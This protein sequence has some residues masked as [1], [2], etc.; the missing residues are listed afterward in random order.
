MITEVQATS[1]QGTLL[2][3]PLGEVSS[4]IFIKEIEGLDPV[5]AII[6]STGFPSQTGEQYQASKRGARDII[7]HLG[8]E[9]DY[10]LEEIADVRNRIYQFFMPRTTVDL[11]FVDHNGVVFGISGMIESC[12]APLFVQ[13]PAVD[14]VVRCFYSDFVNPEVVF[15]SDLTVSN[16][17]M[18]TIE[19]VGTVET[20]FKFQLFPDRDVDEFTLYNEM[21]NGRLRQF[22]FAFP[23]HVGDS[24]TIDTVPGERGVTLSRSSAQSSIL[25]AKTPQSVWLDFW[26]GT[27]KFRA[28][29]EGAGIPFIL[30]YYNRYG[31]L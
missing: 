10:F 18:T 14:V 9:A 15:D 30:T 23:L 31:G 16:T 11:A 1:I 28:Y 25:Y 12:K 3:M 17:V 6:V 7:L 26:P 19:Y 22:D 5:P 8:M 24:V 2:N 4:G 13:D 29:A 21:P 27:N 20:G